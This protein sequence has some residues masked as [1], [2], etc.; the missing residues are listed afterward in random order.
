MAKVT[1]IAEVDLETG[2]FEVTFR[3][4]SNPGC[5]IELNSVKAAFQKVAA[6][7]EVSKHPIST[8]PKQVLS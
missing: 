1:I 4:K 3:N 5:P 8:G 7:F 2:D 6:A